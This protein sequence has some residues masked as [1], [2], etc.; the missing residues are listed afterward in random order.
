MKLVNEQRVVLVP[1]ERACILV[2]PVA[3]ALNVSQDGEAGP[4]E[5]L[6]H[7]GENGENHVLHFRDD[8][9]LAELAGLGEADLGRPLGHAMVATDNWVRQEYRP[10]FDISW[11][12]ST[13]SPTPHR[14]AVRAVP[15]R[16][17]RFFVTFRGSLYSVRAAYRMFLTR[18]HNPDSGVVVLGTC[19]FELTRKTHSELCEEGDRRS[20]A[21]ATYDELLNSTFCLVP[22]GSHPGSIRLAEVMS[23][24]CVPV[25]VGDDYVPPFPSLID[26]KSIAFE[27]CASCHDAILPTL[28]AVPDHVVERMRHGVLVAHNRYFSSEKAR[29]SGVLEALTERLTFRALPF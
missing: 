11:P 4:H 6:E 29:W 19:K 21:G 15:A 26:W 16:L 25:L 28:R 7:W 2:A 13:S 10:G 23:V 5:R 24:G 12:L 27:F 9:T 17:R 22:G 1:P 14:A 3:R 8:S 20:A 18:L